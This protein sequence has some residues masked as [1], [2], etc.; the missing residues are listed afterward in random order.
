MAA[1]TV[2]ID[3][4]S[5]TYAMTGWR[6]GY[7]VCRADLAAQL[8]RIETNLHSC[9]SMLTQRAALCALRSSQEPSHVMAA[10]FRR[11]ARLITDLL[12]DIPGVR[13]VTPRGAFYVFPNVSGACRAMGLASANELCDHL[14]LEAGVAVLPR[15]CFGRRIEDQEYIRLSFATSDE[16]IIEGVR[17][18]RQA[19]ADRS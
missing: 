18:I 6:I 8:S 12:N 3:G 5:K 2:A 11:R 17:R 19:V 1:R 14:L 7:A 4:F 15:T 16:N 13:C 9:T 10:A